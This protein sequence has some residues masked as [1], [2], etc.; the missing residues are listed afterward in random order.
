MTNNEEWFSRTELLLGRDN[1][2]KLKDSHVL[3]VGL[4][5]VGA[6]AAEQLC[7]SGIGKMTVVDADNID[8]T[9]INRQLPALHTTIGKAKSNIIAKRFRN[10][11]PN[12]EITPIQEFIKDEKIPELLKAAKY[13]YVVDAIDS[14]SPKAHLLINAKKMDYN[15]ISSMGA[16]GKFDPTEIRIADISKSYNCGLARALRKKLHRNGIYKGIK[17]IF[18]P[19]ER[20]CPVTQ[21]GSG[22]VN[23]T[24]VGTISYMPASF[25][26]FCASVV[27]NDI[28]K[29]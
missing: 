15:I 1:L 29:Q 7:R 17:V 20:N 23:N 25:G 2:K 19:E 12:I 16:G 21:D 26:C 9:N 6:Y 24:I 13:D 27:I 28:I 3:I 22:T 18:S 14:L 8:I 10:I 4:G 5:G 11:N